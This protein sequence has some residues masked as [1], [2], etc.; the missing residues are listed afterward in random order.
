MTPRER[1]RARQAWLVRQVFQQVSAR[2]SIGRWREW[3][4]PLVLWAPRLA[5]AGAIFSPQAS[6]RVQTSG[7]AFVSEEPNLLTA[8]VCTVNDMYTWLVVCSAGLGRHAEGAILSLAKNARHSHGAPRSLD[9]Q[10]RATRDEKALRGLHPFQRALFPDPDVAN[11]QNGEENQHFDQAKETH[12]FELDCP[13]EKKNGF[14]VEDDEQDG[15]DVITDR[16]AAAGKSDRI[17]A[18]FVRH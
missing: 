10:R 14:Y 17:D 15:N 5:G 9:R 6:R 2:E 3:A 7:P 13:R 16:V 8:C 4:A 12:R 11:D 1:A 18:A